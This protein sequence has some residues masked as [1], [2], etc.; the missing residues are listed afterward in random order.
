MYATKGTFVATRTSVRN[1]YADQ[2]TMQTHHLMKQVVSTRE[3]CKKS[4]L[5]MKINDFDGDVD[6]KTGMDDNKDVNNV[7]NVNNVSN[8]SNVSN[9]N[10]VNDINES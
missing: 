10:N 5:E 6:V 7:N 1:S 2:Q 4:E 8:V 9:V 3:R